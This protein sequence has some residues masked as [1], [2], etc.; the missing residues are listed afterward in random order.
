LT[1]ILDAPAVGRLVGGLVGSAQDSGRV[2]NGIDLGEYLPMPG[3]G[4]NSSKK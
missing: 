2:K 3:F 4:K 1:E